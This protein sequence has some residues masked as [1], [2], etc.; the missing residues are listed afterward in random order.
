MLPGEL[1]EP[2][3]ATTRGKLE[4]EQAQES[5]ERTTKGARVLWMVAIEVLR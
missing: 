4:V 2:F 1:A 3:F 5:P